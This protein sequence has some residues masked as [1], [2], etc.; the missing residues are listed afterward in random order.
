MTKILFIGLVGRLLVWTL[1][2]SGPTRRIWQL[3]SFLD[4]LAACDFC[5]GF[6]VFL[7]LVIVFDVNVFDLLGYYPVLSEI[8]TALV[9]S[10]VVHIA[11]IGWKYQHGDHEAM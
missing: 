5:M 2:T 11:R 4:E 7:P 10:F 6:W 9:F 1:Q 8:V 3:H